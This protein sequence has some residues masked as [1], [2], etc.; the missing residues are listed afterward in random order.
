MTMKTGRNQPCPCGSGKKFKKCCLDKAVAPS[1]ELYYR[2]LS[3][4]HDRLVDR[5]VNHAGRIFG[6]ESIHV[7]MNDFLLWPEGDD[8]VTEETLDRA[9]PLF[10]PWY[11]FN[12]EYMP[13]D[14]GPELPGPARR[15]VADLYAEKQGV[16]LDTLERRLIDGINRKPYSFLE[17]QSVNKGRGMTLTDILK[18]TRIEVQ[19]HT[20]SQYVNPGDVLFGRAVEVDGVGMLIGLSPT[21]IPPGRKAEII[22]FRKQLCRGRSAVTDDTLN[23]WHVETRELYFN[24]DRSLHTMP[25]L[26]NTDGDVLEF[27]RLVYEISSVDEAFRKLCDLCV[28]MT[29]EELAADAE[30]DENNGMVRVEI[31]WG[32]QGHKK[33]SG[34]P[35]TI[36]GRMVIDGR[37]L[38]AEVNSAERAKTL[39]REIDARLGKDGRFKLDEIQD[40]DAMMSRHAAGAAES[41]PSSENEELMQHPEVQAQVAEMFGRHW[42]SWVDR[43]IPALGGKTPREAV[44]TADGREAVEALLKDAERGHGQDSF[45]AEINRKGTRQVREMLG[46]ND[47]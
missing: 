14:G 32:R 29:P 35:N 15:T 44:K 22:Q 43:E 40:F 12:W 5:L 24:I 8:K 33:M 3:Q 20:G 36:L 17:V 27:H 38:T 25:L 18:G 42:E 19:E 39:R 41:T 4:A 26:H 34:M 31:P 13:F 23:S 6:T 45:T 16:K 37:R 28:T 46:L 21:L 1:Q 2:R 10:W 30:F 11:V 47:R 7:A 9:G